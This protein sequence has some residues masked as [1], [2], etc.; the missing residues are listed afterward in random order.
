M[1]LGSGWGTELYRGLP[2]TTREL[3]KSPKMRPWASL[4]GVTPLSKRWLKMVYS[5]DSDTLFG[6]STP[7]IG[8]GGD[9]YTLGTWDTPWTWYP[10]P[11]K[12]TWMAQQ[13]PGLG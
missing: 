7:K 2:L 1:G 9:P 13:V 11:P 12:S 5:L 10:P 4:L 6:F 3:P 8:G